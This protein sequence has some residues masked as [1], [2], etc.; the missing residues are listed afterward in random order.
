MNRFVS[1]LAVALVSSLFAAG[2]SKLKNCADANNKGQSFCENDANFEG[3]QCS[4]DA[5]VDGKKDE[6]ECKNWEASQAAKDV[7]AHADANK[8]KDACTGASAD[9][10]G[11]DKATTQCSWNDK[12]EE[13]KKCFASRK[14]KE[15]EAKPAAPAAN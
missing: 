1:L 13:G 12:N 7:C 14:A 5:K 4:W 11:D 8:D 3:A 10:A 2:C 9:I 6:G 15:K